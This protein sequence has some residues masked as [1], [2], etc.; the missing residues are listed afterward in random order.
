[1]LHNCFSLHSHEQ[2]GAG[3]Q[4]YLSPKI[5]DRKH[6]EENANKATIYQSFKLFY[7]FSFLIP[8]NH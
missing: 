1:M 4:E 2:R 7:D 6:I 3:R 8:S 5:L